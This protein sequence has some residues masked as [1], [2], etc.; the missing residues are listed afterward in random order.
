MR[1]RVYDDTEEAGQEIRME[2]EHVSPD[3]MHRFMEFCYSGDYLY[4]ENGSD[5]PLKDKDATEALP[6]LL[7]HAKLYVFADTFNIASLGELSRNKII[8]LTPRFG[9][10]EDR[11]HGLAM[12]SLMSYVLNNIPAATETPDKL[13]KFLARYAGSLIEK[14]GGY[15]EF[16]AVLASSAREDFFR[17]FCRCLKA[18]EVQAPWTDAE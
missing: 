15:P 13:V 2:M 6:L 12:I 17:V 9:Q 18:G 1:T 14:L 16:H 10:L 8:A 5:G 7:T 4:A 11:A 3:T